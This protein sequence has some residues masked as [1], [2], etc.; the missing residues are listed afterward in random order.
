MPNPLIVYEEIR[1][2]ILSERGWDYYTLK[3]FVYNGGE[4]F[5]R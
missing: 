2:Y 1:I 3:R 5:V 4:T